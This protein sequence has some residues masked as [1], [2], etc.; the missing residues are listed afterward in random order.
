MLVEAIKELYDHNYWAMNKLLQ[1]L[2][3]LSQAQLHTDLLNG[4]GSI[5]TTLVHI[6]R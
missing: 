3:G 2:E 6:V 1:V 4:V 5:H